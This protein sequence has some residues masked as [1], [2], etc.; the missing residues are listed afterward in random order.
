MSWA[1][2]LVGGTFRSLH[3]R[4]F[5]LWI[6][7]SLVSNAGTWM[8]ATAQDWLV[9]T[10]L[11]HNKASAVGIVVG[12]QFAPQLLFV[13]LSGTLADHVDRRKLLVAT[14]AAMGLLALGLGALTVSG[15]VQLWHV[16]VF[17][18][19]FGCA[20]AFD[21]P[22]RQTFVSDLVGEEGIGNAVALNGTTFNL[23]RMIGP[24]VAGFSIAI[25]GTG[26]VF[27]INAATYL[28]V[29]GGL[30]AMRVV[31]LHL[32][33]RG[34]R[35]RGGM[36]EG[37]RYA[38]GRPDI[39]ALFLMMGLIGTLGMNFS[40]I[41]SA[42]LVKV[43][44]AGAGEYGM[45]SSIMAV[46]SVIG[47]LIAAR[48]AR[49]SMALI[50]GGAALFGCAMGIAALMPT[51]A[52]FVMMLT[53]VGLALQTFITSTNGLVQLAVAPDMRGRVLAIRTAIMLGGMPIGAPIVGFVADHFGPRWAMGFGTCAGLLAALV[54]M[55]YLIT[56]RGLRITRRGGRLHLHVAPDPYWDWK[57]L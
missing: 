13:A 8:Q 57:G 17:A 20:L 22:A 3:N 9:L 37:F 35:P 50:V 54:G 12:L 36:L 30:M 41:N 32:D 34:G 46:G 21:A 19:L 43:F 44:H 2:N 27:M 24:A 10:E 38:A 14:Q 33:G 25:V 49:P 55:I 48:R 29:I 7:G 5:R 1:A 52:L 31:D 51:L 23:A 11:T 45:L 18:F 42:M 28:V 16:Y 40:V 6:A 26:W 39:L 4:N 53:V 56:R 15:V 47:A